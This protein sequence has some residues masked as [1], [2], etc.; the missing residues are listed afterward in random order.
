LPPP[1]FGSTKTE[2]V[3]PAHAKTADAELTYYWHVPLF[4]MSTEQT[5]EIDGFTLNEDVFKRALEDIDSNPELYD[6]FSG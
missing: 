2:R 6:S 4:R 5:E 1:S 3:S